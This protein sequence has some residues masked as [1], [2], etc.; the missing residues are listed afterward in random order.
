MCLCR[1][2]FALLLTGLVFCFFKCFIMCRHYN[3]LFKQPLRSPTFWSIDSPCGIH[4]SHLDPLA[5]AG[6]LRS[7]CETALPAQAVQGP[8]RAGCS[9]PECCGSHPLV[10]ADRFVSR[11]A[12]AFI[13]FFFLTLFTSDLHKYKKS[14]KKSLARR[15]EYRCEAD[16]KRASVRR[17]QRVGRCLPSRAD[18]LYGR[19]C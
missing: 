1:W 12:A 18:S 5:P 10:Q 17:S 2:L 14:Y 6:Q 3:V 7:K 19:G 4:T 11:W 8:G 15:W 16:A 9:V 13:L